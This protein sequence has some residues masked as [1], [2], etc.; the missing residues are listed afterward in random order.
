MICTVNRDSDTLYYDTARNRLC[1]ID[2]TR[3]PGEF[4]TLSLHT[5]EE[6][7]EAIRLL[8]IR[9]APALGVAVAI[10]LAVLA[11]EMHPY[12]SALL[13]EYAKRILNTRPTAVN[14][15]WAA[16]RMLEHAESQKALQDEALRVWQEDIDTCRRIGEQGSA[17]LRDGDSVLTHCNAGR[18]AAVRYGTAL[19]PIYVAAEQGKRV[20]VFVD[21]TRPLLQGARLTAY[22]L[23]QAGIPVTLMC[24]NMAASLLANH[25]IRAVLVGADRIARNGD[26]ANKVGSLG[27][28][29]IAKRVSV[30]FYVCAP[31]STVDFDCQNGR[32]IPIEMRDGSEITELWY[33]KRMTPRNISVYNPA[34][35]VIPADLI[36]AFV[37]ERGIIK[38]QDL[39][40]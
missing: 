9:G 2:Q 13:R 40:S 17:L 6:I 20:H 4:V 36:S 25:R 23:V 33:Q 31:F 24:D 12:D 5:V 26:T 21:E 22:E 32:D 29:V 37:T 27:L 14:L 16:E 30:P 28:A 39:S 18:L 35:D 10:G 19:A 38:P 11:N 3:L 34:F 8:R 15:R 7:E 1:L